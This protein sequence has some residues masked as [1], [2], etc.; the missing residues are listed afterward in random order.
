MRIRKKFVCLSP[1]WQCGAR[2]CD[3]KMIVLYKKY[4][5]RMRLVGGGVRDGAG[6]AKILVRFQNYCLF[7]LHK[8]CKDFLWE[9]RSYLILLR[10]SKIFLLIFTWVL[11]RALRT[12]QYLQYYRS[13]LSRIYKWILQDR[14]TLTILG[15]GVQGPSRNTIEAVSIASS[16]SC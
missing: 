9:G 15:S 6:Q 1:L 10:S 4:L 2:T 7:S 12:V 8:S 16:V 3:I 5:K 14:V 11:I 13:F